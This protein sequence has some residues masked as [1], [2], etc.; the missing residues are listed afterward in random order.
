VWLGLAAPPGQLGR[1]A[2]RIALVRT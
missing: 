1:I 2:A